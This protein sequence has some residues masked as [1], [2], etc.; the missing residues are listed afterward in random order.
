[1]KSSFLVFLFIGLAGILLIREQKN[2]T[3][4]LTDDRLMSAIESISHSGTQKPL[5]T[6]VQHNEQ[7][8]DI[9]GSLQLTDVDIAL[10]LRTVYKFSPRSVG[11]A[12]HLGSKDRNAL[13]TD[14]LNIQTNLHSDIYFGLLFSPTTDRYSPTFAIPPNLKVTGTSPLRFSG[15]PLPVDLPQNVT[16]GFLNVQE[17]I[18][19]RNLISPLATYHDAP[20]PSFAL[21][22]L[23]VS[24]Q[25]EN[26]KVDA[27]SY[28]KIREGADALIESISLDDLLL[29]MEKFESGRI[30]N[31]LETLLSGR[32]IML[33][34][35]GETERTAILASGKKYSPVHVQALLLASILGGKSATQASPF[36]NLMILPLIYLAILFSQKIKGRIL[37]FL[38][39]CLLA[40]L[41]SGGLY[42]FAAIWLPP[43]PAFSMAACLFLATFFT[44]KN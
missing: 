24:N 21:A 23:L 2:G 5:I 39:L 16:V 13:V 19:G 28:L 31:K 11:I 41:V 22:A 44:R 9:T 12:G 3:F 42:Y 29:E 7:S 27:T 26:R 1:M 8:A 35:D 6:L 34:L 43:I 36:W 25:K 17:T 18:A 20:L 10:F 4:A 33:G 38:L 30:S 15:I 14:I 32:M 37:F 40:A